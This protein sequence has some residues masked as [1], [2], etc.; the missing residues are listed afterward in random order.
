MF[1]K[2][3]ATVNSPDPEIGTLCSA[4]AVLTEKQS[5]SICSYS[6]SFSAIDDALLLLLPARGENLT[7][8]ILIIVECLLWLPCRCD[9]VG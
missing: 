6:A 4:K 1:G 7:L 2:D 8:P 5:L 9:V 3:F